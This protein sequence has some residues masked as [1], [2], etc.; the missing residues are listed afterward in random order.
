MHLVR[1]KYKSKC[2]FGIGRSI[3]TLEEEKVYILSRRKKYIYFRT[4]GVYERRV[5]C[6]GLCIYTFGDSVRVCIHA[7]V[8]MQRSRR[9][10]CM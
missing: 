4:A 1:A 10:V 6:V 5:L 2:I 9:H 8:P 7:V 3:Y